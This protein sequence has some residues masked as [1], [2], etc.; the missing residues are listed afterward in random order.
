MD[1]RVKDLSSSVLGFFV[2]LFHCLM[3]E[4]VRKQWR[5]HLCC[6]RFRPNNYSGNGF[7]AKR[8][9]WTWHALR[10]NGQ[11]HFKV[12]NLLLLVF[13]PPHLDSSRTVTA[14]STH[15]KSNLVNSDSLASDSTV[16]TRI[17]SDSSTGSGPNQHRA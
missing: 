10:C 6:G 8:C 5:I 15:G 14:V 12:D 11:R 17:F 16:T 9:L 2:F 13:S 4:N 7:Q 3:K 1:Q